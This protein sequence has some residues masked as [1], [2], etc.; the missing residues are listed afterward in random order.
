MGLSSD[1]AATKE[2]VWKKMGDNGLEIST[3]EMHTGGEPLR[4]IISG[5]PEIKGDTILAKRRYLRENL[6]H[7]RKLMMFEPRGHYDMYGA[8]IVPPGSEMADLGVIFMDSGGYSTMCGHAVIALGRYAVDSGLLS[9]DVSRS[10]VG[11]VPAFIECPCGVVKALL[12]IEEGKSGRVRFTSVPAFA[13]G[14]DLEVDTEKFGKIKVDIGFGGAFYVLV[15]GERLGVDVRST[16]VDRSPCGS[17]VTARVAVQYARKQIGMH[18]TRVF[19]NGL[20]GS[21]FTGQ[22]VK[23]TKC[24]E[25]NAVHVEVAGSA[26]YIGKCSFTVE[27]EDPFKQG[28]LLK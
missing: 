5:Y 24:G 2:L 3:V 17:G 18:Q 25:F 15:S 19:E 21:K 1:G 12:N 23:E 26:H 27:K 9:T 7:I 11:E 14:L 4:I 28:F 22:V 10:S 20:V 16:R 6:D 13:F 8:V